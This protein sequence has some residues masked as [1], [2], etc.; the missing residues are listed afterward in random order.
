MP[1]PWRWWRTLRRR[2]VFVA[3]GSHLGKTVGGDAADRKLL[4]LVK[5][6][7]QKMK[8]YG[9]VH[10]TD[11]WLVADCAKCSPAMQHSTI[12]ATI[13]MRITLPSDWVAPDDRVYAVCE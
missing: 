1:C 13:E 5:A 9:Q 4:S 8:T 10:L 7:K 11:A 6:L 12:E 3:S 2:L